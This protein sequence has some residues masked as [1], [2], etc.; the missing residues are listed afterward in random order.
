MVNTRLSILNV[1]LYE[2]VP[3]RDLDVA[4]MFDDKI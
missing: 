4:K 2:F 1:F 3:M